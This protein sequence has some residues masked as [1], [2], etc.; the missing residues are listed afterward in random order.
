MQKGALRTREEAHWSSFRRAVVGF[1]HTILEGSASAPE[2]ERGCMCGAD[3]I[4]I[5][6]RDVGALGGGGKPQRIARD[7]LAGTN[8]RAYG[9]DT[10]NADVRRWNAT[11]DDEQSQRS[12]GKHTETANTQQKL[13]LIGLEEVDKSFSGN[14]PLGKDFASPNAPS[15]ASQALS[16]AEHQ[17]A[18]TKL[19]LAMTESERDEL[20]FRLLQSNPR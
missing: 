9:A 19:K 11:V 1:Q 8:D 2:E 18:E 16:V 10:A 6:D 14:N 5:S 12:G 4:I 7:A 17:L 3:E 20:E 13:E 15:H